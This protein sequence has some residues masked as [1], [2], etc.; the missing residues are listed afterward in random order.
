MN[1]PAIKFSVFVP[2]LGSKEAY[3]FIGLNQL[4]NNGFSYTGLAFAGSGSSGAI[5][6][7]GSKCPSTCIK[8][9]DC[10]MGGGIIAN[11]TCFMCGAG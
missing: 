3:Q 2:R 4:A 6:C 5:P 7:E 9:L 10:V 1:S 11:M 8:I